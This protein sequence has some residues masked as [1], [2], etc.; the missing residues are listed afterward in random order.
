M[1]LLCGHTEAFRP[2]F[3][4]GRLGGTEAEF[5]SPPWT[6][7]MLTGQGVFGEFLLRIRKEATSICHH[8]K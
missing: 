6:T 5:R 3:P 7:Q 4:T 8:C 2:S 1:M